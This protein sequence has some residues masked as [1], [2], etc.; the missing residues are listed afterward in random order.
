M[1]LELAKT[2]NHNGITITEEDLRDM[3]ATFTGDV[4]VTIGHEADDSMPAYGWVTA[5]EVSEDGQTLTGE[6]ELNEELQQAIAEG[7]YKNWSIGAG[8]NADEQMYLHHVAFLGAVPPMIKGLKLIEMGD[9]S[10][11]VTFAINGGCSLTLSDA[12]LSE[13]ASLR[14]EKKSALIK[15]LSDASAGKIPFGKREEL[16][17]FADSQLSA[18]GEEIVSMLAEIFESV[19]HPVREGISQ[20]IRTKNA[21][22]SVNVFSKI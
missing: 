22:T 20:A 3:A 19:K 7:R 6:L 15:K 14:K 16:I 9:R 4:P 11:I 18:G 10:D 8:R 13:Y 17:R 1:K 2:G 5:L 21:E 12:E